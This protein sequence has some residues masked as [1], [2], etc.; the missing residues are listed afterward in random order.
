MHA[1]PDSYSQV[2]TKKVQVFKDSSHSSKDNE[3]KL[4]QLPA[5]KLTFSASWNDSQ[6]LGLEHGTPSCSKQLL[7]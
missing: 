3:S 7:K 4:K 5:N 6:N 2:F 1:T